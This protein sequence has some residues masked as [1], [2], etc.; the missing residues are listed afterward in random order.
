MYV[1]YVNFVDLRMVTRYT[2]YGQE[3]VYNVTKLQP[4]GV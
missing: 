2:L 1:L 3:N 4:P